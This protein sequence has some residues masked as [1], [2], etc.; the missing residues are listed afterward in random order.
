MMTSNAY[1]Q[2]ILDLRPES[3]KDDD[4]LRQ[5]EGLTDHILFYPP[6]VGTSPERVAENVA[7]IVDTF[8]GA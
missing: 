4:Q 6:T 3:I 1:Y 2:R 7:A 5:W 8:G